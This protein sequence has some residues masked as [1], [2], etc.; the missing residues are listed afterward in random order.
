[1]PFG[2][3]CG[4]LHRCHA[5][6]NFHRL[7]QL[8][9]CGIERQSGGPEQAEDVFVYAT[10][11]DPKWQHLLATVTKLGDDLLGKFEGVLELAAYV[12]LKLSFGC[13]GDDVDLLST[14]VIAANCGFGPA[15][16]FDNNQ[17][18][19]SFA[20]F[21]HGALGSEGVVHALSENGK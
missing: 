1:V 14:V 12:P 5:S 13:E 3:L 7:D 6:Q 11:L 17:R 9:R 18:K 20:G 8:C 19:L 10:F 16:W 2:Q 4:L 21:W 15:L